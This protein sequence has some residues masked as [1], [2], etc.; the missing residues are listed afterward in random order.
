MPDAMRRAM[1]VIVSVAGGE[2][3]EAPLDLWPKPEQSRSVFLRPARV[4]HL[5]GVEVPRSDIERVLST[6]GFV[7]APKD[8]RLAVQVPGW[9]PDVTREVHLLEDETWLRG[10]DVLP[11]DLLP[12][13]P[14]TVPESPSLPG[15]T[16]G[17]ARPGP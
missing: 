10:Y 16:R 14:A 13:R 15:L 1:D 4:S 2:V 9:R 6:I 3:R 11:Q 8:E 12:S 17:R 7:V 5:L